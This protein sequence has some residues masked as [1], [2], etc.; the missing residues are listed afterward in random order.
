MVTGEVVRVRVE[1]GYARGEKDR[2][3]AE[4]FMLLAPGPQNMESGAPSPTAIGEF[5]PQLWD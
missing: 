2:F 4:G 5:T 3:G 1:E